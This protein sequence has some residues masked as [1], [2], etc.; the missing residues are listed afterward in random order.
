MEDEMN[1]T[2]VMEG[3]ISLVAVAACT[4][5]FTG[6]QCGAFLGEHSETRS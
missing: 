4:L 1:I 3:L 5:Y 6:L 2:V